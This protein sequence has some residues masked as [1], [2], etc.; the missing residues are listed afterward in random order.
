[1]PLKILIVEDEASVAQNLCDLLSELSLDFEILDI[2]ES[3]EDSIAFIQ[4]KQNIDLA[5]FDIQLADGDSFAI[6]EN[7]EVNFPVI[8]TTAYDKYAI[9][10]FKVNSIDY[11]MKPIVKNELREAIAKYEKYFMP[12][13][14]FDNKNILKLLNN[15]IKDSNKN[16]KNLLVHYKDKLIPISLDRIS[17]FYLENEIVYCITNKAEKYIIDNTLDGL[18]KLIDSKEFFRLNRQFVSSRKSIKSASIHFN[19]KMKIELNPF[20]NIDVLISKEKIKSFK[21]WLIG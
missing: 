17:Y 11:L 13:K 3:V 14:E 21:L 18:C 19:R 4:K 5:F 1:M 15:A 2:L 12:K 10:A 9:K 7:I 16:I 6:F 8:F 20:I